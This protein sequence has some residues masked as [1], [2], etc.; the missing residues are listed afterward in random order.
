LD[1]SAVA[2]LSLS[3]GKVSAMAFSGKRS[4]P[5]WYYSF[6]DE[7]RARARIA[8]HAYAVK[9]KEDGRKERADCGN[10]DCPKK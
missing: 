7:E 10:L 6:R 1:C 9:R 5:D 2:F 8:E 4:K 3:G